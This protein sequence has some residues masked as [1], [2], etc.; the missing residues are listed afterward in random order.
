[1][2]NSKIIVKTADKSYPVYFGNGI[3]NLTG[4]LIKKKIPNARKVFLIVD[5]KLPLALL[6]K[7]KKSLKKYELIIFKLHVTEK[8][9]N[10]KMAF[11]LIENL[12][13]HN[14]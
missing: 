7:L 9:K 5:K 13:K 8:I 4:S 11:K 6:K 1:M 12:L 10:Y 14:F 3:I 2:K